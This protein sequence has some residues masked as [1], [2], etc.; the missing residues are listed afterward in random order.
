MLGACKGNAQAN[1]HEETCEKKKK[2]AAAT[3][4]AKDIHP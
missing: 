3:R 4:E 2:K 1:H